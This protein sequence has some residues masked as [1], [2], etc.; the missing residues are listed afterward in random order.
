MATDLS[1]YRLTKAPP[2]FCRGDFTKAYGVFCFA[3]VLRA[4][5]LTKLR[6]LQDT[7]KAMISSLM[8]GNSALVVQCIWSFVCFS[9]GINRE[10]LR[11]VFERGYFP[12]NLVFIRLLGAFAQS[13]A[14][15]IFFLFFRL[16]K[17][18]AAKSLFYCFI[19]A[20]E[21]SFVVDAKLLDSFS[22]EMLCVSITLFS[23]QL[24]NRKR[25]FG[26]FLVQILC[27]IVLCLSLNHPFMWVAF[28]IFITD[29]HW[30]K[31]RIVLSVIPLCISLY[32]DSPSLKYWNNLFRWL[33]FGQ[34]PSLLINQNNLR[35][36]RLVNP[37]TI[38][39]CVILLLGSQKALLN[40]GFILFAS[41][42]SKSSNHIL[43]LIMVIASK[44]RIPE[45]A[46]YV[47][48]SLE[49]AMFTIFFSWSFPLGVS[50]KLHRML[51]G[52][53]NAIYY[54]HFNSHLV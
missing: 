7:D 42:L 15:A 23:T 46:I 4:C 5:G 29:F 19:L 20:V 45:W 37:S 41:G 50:H 53:V 17:V 32:L 18:D 22:I 12:C 1:I 48:G 26:Y 49:L 27:C 16:S 36:V 38:L 3:F 39:C 40:I 28:V 14:I 21:H 6:H 51:D 54:N 35:F 9:F 52:I 11:N 25:Q 31:M 34:K 47:L 33:S 24:S 2:L 8:N 30:L 43:L 10:S 44:N 13:F